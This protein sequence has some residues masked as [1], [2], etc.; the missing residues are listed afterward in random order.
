MWFRPFI[1]KAVLKKDAYPLVEFEGKDLAKPRNG[2]YLKKYY[3]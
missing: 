3:S 1:M 2:I